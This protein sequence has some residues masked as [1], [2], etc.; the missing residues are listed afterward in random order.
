VDVCADGLVKTWSVFLPIPPAAAGGIF[1]SVAHYSFKFFMKKTAIRKSVAGLLM[2]VAL[3]ASAQEFPAAQIKRGSDLYER[4]CSPCH[5]NRMK[6]P[7][8]AFD[9]MT[10]PA[11]QGARFRNSVAKGKN[12]MPP[13]ESMLKPEDIDALWAYVV[14]GEKN[15]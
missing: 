14:A 4:N 9:L 12:S 2:T 13:W 15:N 8:G 11:D 6:N 10:F 5:G 7:E 1:F 3:S